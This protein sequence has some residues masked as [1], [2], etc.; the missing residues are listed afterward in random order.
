MV[1]SSSWIWLFTGTRLSFYLPHPAWLFSLDLPSCHSDVGK[2]NTRGP[3]DSIFRLPHQS[4][5]WE[6]RLKVTWCGDPLFRQLG[7]HLRRPR[8]DG[9]SP[10]INEVNCCSASQPR[11]YLKRQPTS[12]V[13]SRLTAMR[14]S[15]FFNGCKID[16]RG[17]PC[18]PSSVMEALSQSDPSSK[19]QR[20]PAK[21]IPTVLG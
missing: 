17:G 3:R 19:S 1:T 6:F 2:A 16:A 9:S 8:A 5:D 15:V 20:P 12:T 13:R 21:T 4:T 18:P 11:L 14:F 7:S 10:R